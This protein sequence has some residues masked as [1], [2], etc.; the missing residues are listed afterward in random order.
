MNQ[1]IKMQKARAAKEPTVVYDCSEYRISIIPLN[2]RIDIKPACKM[3][4]P[5]RGMDRD[6][7]SDLD[8]GL[9][10]AHAVANMI[11]DRHFIRPIQSASTM[12]GREFF[13]QTAVCAV[14][15]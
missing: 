2:Y 6:C 1:N 4:E 10:E 13:S 8:K 3:K 5:W 7:Y 12:P 15:L 11:I 14:V 9:A